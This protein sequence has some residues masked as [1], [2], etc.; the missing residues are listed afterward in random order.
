MR[1]PPG[2]LGK[3][4]GE[5]A[6]MVGGGPRLQGVRLFPQAPSSPNPRPASFQSV[7]ALSSSHASDGLTCDKLG[8]WR[9]DDGSARPMELYRQAWIS[10]PSTLPR[11]RPRCEGSIWL[12]SKGLGPRIGGMWRVY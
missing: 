8:I 1:K 2:D 4:P 11:P 10:R 5:Q 9:G 6:W 12:V 7:N 3:S